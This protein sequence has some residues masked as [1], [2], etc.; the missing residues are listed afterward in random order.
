MI[1]IFQFNK[2]R[3]D[4]L[5]KILLL[6]DDIELCQTIQEILQENGYKVDTA[7]NEESAIEKTFENSYDLY[8][9]DINLPDGNGIE[10]LKSLKEANDNTPTIFISALVDIESISKAFKVGG[11]DYI[12]KPFFPEELLVRID[13][14]LHK[15][16]DELITYKHLKYNK[17]KK[18]LYIDEK[19]FLLS[20]LLK[21]IF[22]KLISNIGNVVENY[23]LQECLKSPS[24]TA[25]RVAINKLKQQLNI[26]I[27]NIRATGYMIEKI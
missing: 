8:I 23:E 26:E 20:E 14:K 13:A 15:F 16:Q 2:N 4:V 10:L 22:E 9:F 3:M 17:T 12:K 19:L 27:K 18:E 25:L 11:E 6:E 24:S 1:P 7:H 21:C 5:N